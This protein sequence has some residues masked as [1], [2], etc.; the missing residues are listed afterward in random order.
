MDNTTK[1][2]ARLFVPQTFEGVTTV[3]IIDDL[4]RN[5][6][7][8]QLDIRY[9]KH[10]D[11]RDHHLFTDADIV[12]ALGLPYKGYA[13]PDDFYLGVDVPFMDFIHVATYGET[14]KGENIISLVDPDKDPVKVIAELITQSP[15][16]SLFSKSVAFS[17]KS[18]YLIEAV[19]SYRTWTWE[20]NDTTRMLLALYHGSYKWLPRMIKGME[21]MEMLQT[22]APIIKGQMEKMNEYI[23]RKIEMTKTY[24]VDIEGQT[25][26]LRVVFAD[27][28]I[29]ELANALL[30]LEQTSSPVIVCVGR[31]TKSSDMFSI[32]TR[33]VNA[34]KIAYMINEGNGKENVASVFTGVGYAELMGS[35][36]VNKL[37]QVPQ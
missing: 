30:N 35:S 3:A 24:N 11:F 13:L 34:G 20:N 15:E 23:E 9:T 12:L 29:N 14:I 28:Y 4:L 18:W 32:R 25:C 19:N 37:T 6:D 21:L 16:S 33:I 7:D 2:I 8:I 26:I 27:E 36:V 5:T 1:K 22:Y 10:L 17:D 31:A